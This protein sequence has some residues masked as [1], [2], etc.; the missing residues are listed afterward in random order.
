VL[1]EDEADDGLYAGI[2]V[3]QICIE[4]LEWAESKKINNASV[5]S[6]F[7]KLRHEIMPKLMHLSEEVLLT[8]PDTFEKAVKL[9]K[10]SMLPYQEVHLCLKGCMRFENYAP[11]TKRS[12]KDLEECCTVCGLSR[13]NLETKVARYIKFVY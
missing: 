7:W 1:L 12:A 2:N 6:L 5:D 13:F 11:G 8:M 3:A 10:V 9:I 4:V